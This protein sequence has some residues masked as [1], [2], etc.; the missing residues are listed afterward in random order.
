[1]P[2]CNGLPCLLN[3]SICRGSVGLKFRHLGVQVNSIILQLPEL[4]GAGVWV[5]TG[6]FLGTMNDLWG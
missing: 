6:E 5:S 2:G 4:L 1:M 3:L